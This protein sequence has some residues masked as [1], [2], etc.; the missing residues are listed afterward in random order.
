MT[1]G[2]NDFTLAYIISLRARPDKVLKSS[3]CSESLSTT[4]VS[5]SSLEEVAC[6]FKNYKTSTR[7]IKFIYLEVK[8]KFLR[9]YKHSI[10]LN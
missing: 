7:L 5:V 6:S 10:T 3:F 4:K 2:H 8:T 9:S 1:R